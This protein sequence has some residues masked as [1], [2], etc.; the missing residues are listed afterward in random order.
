MGLFDLFSNK[1]NRELDKVLTE[2]TLAM[3]PNGEPDLLRD[4]DRVN[5]L[6][7]GKIP[8]SDLRSFVGGCKARLFSSDNDN[9]EVILESIAMRSKRVLEPAEIYEVYVYFMGEAHDLDKLAIYVKENDGKAPSELQEYMAQ[10]PGQR[11]V[12]V[13]TDH[14]PEGYGDFGLV[15]TNPIPTICIQAS[16]RYLSSLR[17]GGQ[18]VT[19]ERLGSTPSKVSH[20]SVDIYAIKHNGSNVGTVYICPYHRRNSRKAPRGFTLFGAPN[21]GVSPDPSVNSEQTGFAG[22]SSLKSDDLPPQDGYRAATPHPPK[23]PNTASQSTS[24]AAVP[25]RS[26]T[27]E[28]RP[29]PSALPPSSSVV[30]VTAETFDSE[31]LTES[32]RTP[33]L[34][35]FWATWCAPCKL[36]SSSL[37]K[38]ESLYASRLKVVKVDTDKEKELA[39]AFGIR[40]VP[41]CVLFMNGRPIDGFMGAIPESKIKEFLNKHIPTIS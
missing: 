22:L 24:T 12:G 30:H 10:I 6:T 11:A 28:A 17:Y 3:F 18:S 5:K 7:H 33:V 2:F 13:Y 16:N 29:R 23:S 35:D 20:G 34:L 31:V 39:Q 15:E 25:S 41:T 4:C 9:E 38:I 1:K 37:D 14:I 27:A 36:L 8:P 40:S 32:H 26:T 19:H 21:G